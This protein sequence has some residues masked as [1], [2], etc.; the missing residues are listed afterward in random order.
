MLRGSRRR[1]PI[2]PLTPSPRDRPRAKDDLY[3]AGTGG[4][5]LFHLL[6]CVG[7]FVSLVLTLRV[8]IAITRDGI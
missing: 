8:I 4:T 1:D 6:G 3:A 5:P 2:W 7:P